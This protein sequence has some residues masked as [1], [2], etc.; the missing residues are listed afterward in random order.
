MNQFLQQHEGAINAQHTIAFDRVIV[1]DF[2]EDE[3][4]HI[5]GEVI[6]IDEELVLFPLA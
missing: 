1:M 6:V 2:V 3:P 4:E 5:I